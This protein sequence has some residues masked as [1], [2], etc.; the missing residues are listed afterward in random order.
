MILC[1]TCFTSRRFSDGMLQARHT[2]DILV[3]G[4]KP[5]LV[6]TNHIRI[7]VSIMTIISWMI[8]VGK[9]PGLES[10]INGSQNGN[11]IVHNTCIVREK[12]T[13]YSIYKRYRQQ[14][15]KILPYSLYTKLSL[16]HWLWIEYC[17][18]YCILYQSLSRCDDFSNR[19]VITFTISIDIKVLQFHYEAHM[20]TYFVLPI[21]KW[22]WH[23]GQ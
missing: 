6:K 7:T 16:N 20:P 23:S 21:D 14:N 19:T 1:V 8:R 13:I 3:Q 2:P 5:I 22:N 10:Y 17:Y 11:I 12:E 15:L 9:L 18:T 4:W